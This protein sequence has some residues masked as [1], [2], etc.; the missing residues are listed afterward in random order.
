V[1]ARTRTFASGVQSIIRRSAPLRRAL[2]SQP[3]STVTGEVGAMGLRAT[4]SAT[5]THPLGVEVGVMFHNP[6][7]DAFPVG[8]VHRHRRTRLGEMRGD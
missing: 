3:Y 4:G 7:G 1:D 6:G 2:I 8:Q 5:L